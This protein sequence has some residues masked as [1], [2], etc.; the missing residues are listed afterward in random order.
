MWVDGVSVTML[1][2]VDPRPP[3]AGN[4]VANGS[5][6]LGTASWVATFRNAGGLELA[7]AARDRISPADWGVSAVE[8]G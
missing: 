1:P 6:E 4:L 8:G 5:F 2:P 7:S 3:Q